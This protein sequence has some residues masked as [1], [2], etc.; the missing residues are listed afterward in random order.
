MRMK[1]V[2][3]LALAVMIGIYVYRQIQKNNVK[4]VNTSTQPANDQ[5]EGPDVDSR[6][7][8]YLP[9]SAMPGTVE[10]PAQGN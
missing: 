5:F 10:F 2:V 9:T 4:K 3:L 7:G 6:T 8:A 1:N